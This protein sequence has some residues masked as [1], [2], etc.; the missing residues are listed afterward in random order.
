ML[1]C[2]G[3][4]YKVG[5]FDPKDGSGKTIAYDNV[6]LHYT[7]SNNPNVIGTECSQLKIKREQFGKVCKVSA[8]ELVGKDIHVEYQPIGGKLT[9][10]NIM[11]I[12]S[13]K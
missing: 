6:V 2:V 13:S 11:P 5:V 7:S 8:E 9:V 3:C 4:E 12:S 10:T 1:K